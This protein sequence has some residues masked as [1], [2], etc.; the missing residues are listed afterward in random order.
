M[1]IKN[2]V[3]DEAETLLKN[4]HSE[5][6]LWQKELMKYET[7]ETSVSSKNPFVISFVGRF[8]T[9]KS[10]LLNALLGQ[11]LLP[12][13]VTTATTIVT[14]IQSNPV[15]RITMSENG[16][17]KEHTLEEIRQCILNYQVTDS[18]NAAVVSYQLP[19]LWFSNDVELWDTP[20]I[21]DSAQEG[22]LEQITLDALKKTDLC[23]MV[24]DASAVF[25]QKE[26]KY[27]AY[28]NQIMGGNVV[29]AV[30]KTNLLHSL[31]QLED[32]ERIC[33][34][35]LVP[36]K[37]PDSELG[38]YYIMCSKPQEIQLDGFD[39]W[40]K[41]LCAPE[42]ADVRNQYRRNVI[43]A[44]YENDVNIIG[45]QAEL[46]QRQLLEMCDQVNSVHRKLLQKETEEIQD[47]MSALLDKLNHNNSAVENRFLNAD[48]LQ[49][50]FEKSI[51]ASSGN[52]SDDWKSK[53]SSE[54]KIITKCY[55]SNN[56]EVACQLLPDLFSKSD[57]TF[58]WKDSGT[59][60]FPGV[61]LVEQ[62][63][64]GSKAVKIGTA[65]ALG[66]LLFGPAAAA[67]TAMATA[68]VAADNVKMLNQSSENTFKFVNETILPQLRSNFE[69]LVRNKKIEI[70][71]KAE[72]EIADITTGLEPI[73]A[74]LEKTE[75]EV[76]KIMQYIKSDNNN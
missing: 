47:R 19:H 40:L 37:Q 25:S 44:K 68:V 46:Y 65:A 20:G 27:I 5:K 63:E 66:L 28:V 29:Y 53:Y 42:N 36:L 34:H 61:F 60:S 8:K 13:R 50:E 14:K 3:R 51:K 9:G 74:E 64:A 56:F 18:S 69:Q 67:I 12:T 32:V 43:A 72:K 76:Y 39:I 31:E 6:L 24:F 23:I 54:S 11:E 10:S 35:I 71:S 1:N 17:I 21:G 52:S 38:D 22:R 45:Q 73:L 55:F 57:F 59:V 33:Q 16:K 26:K 75:K 30:N 70:R 15:F 7:E 4:I 62:K 2:Q 41:E 49:V 48:T 58:L